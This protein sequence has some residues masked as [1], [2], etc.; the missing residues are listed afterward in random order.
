[1][2]IP[3]LFDD[4]STAD[5]GQKRVFALRAAFALIMAFLIAQINLDYVESWFYDLRVATKPYTANSNNIELVYIKPTT[6]QTHKGLPDARTQ[7]ATLQKLLDAGAKAVVYDFA[8]SESP[9]SDD[10]KNSWE[11]SIVHNKN[12]FVATKDTPL[13]G[14]EKSLYLADPLEQVRTVPAPK[15]SDTINFAKDSVTRRMMLSYQGSTMLQV[16]LASLFNPAVLDLNNVRGNFSFYETVQAYIDFHRP[17]TFPDTTFD[18][19][20]DNGADLSKFKDKIVLIGTDLNISESDYI[21]TPYS[22]IPSSMTRI[23][24]QAN[25]ID[26]LIRNSSP[27]KAPPY[28]N[29][30]LLALVS[31]LAIQI[32]LSMRPATGLMIL[33]GTLFGFSVVAF[34]FFWLFGIWI[35][36][37]HPLLAGF[38]CYYFFIPYRLIIE[39]RRSWEYYQKNKLLSQVE[40]LKT[41]FISMMSHDLKTPIARIQGMSDVILS[42]VTPISSQQREAVDTIKHSAD[43]LLKFINAILNYGRI[44]SQGVQLHLQTK[45]INNVL[46]EVIRKHEFLAK[47][48][49]IQI[50]SELDPLFPIPM[51]ADL[52]KQVLSNLV[53]NAIKYSPED[54]KIMITSEEKDDFVVIQVTDQ[55]P[56]IPQDELNNIFMKF[57]RSKNVKSS[58][59][60]G[61][62]LGLYLAKYFTELHRGRIFVESNDGK[63]STFTVELP[64]EQGGLHA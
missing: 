60:K 17:R 53:E 40:E 57:F 27:I 50:V 28:V 4:I 39:N 14:E 49:R 48:K 16:Y 24:M 37:A 29:W 12:V 25:I 7:E 43:D 3:S 54:T 63:G 9:G 36:M 33:V 47:V 22:K 10:E 13:K 11:A 35:P 59:I 38:L 20:A 30:I 32:V 64:M 8:I 15:T 58:P 31:V 21:R 56:G 52:M 55:G 5:S 51:D 19:I 6:V 26:T 44:E 18:T 42:D 62:G 2:T 23:E 1:M 46:Q 41:N 45:D 61:S 34:A